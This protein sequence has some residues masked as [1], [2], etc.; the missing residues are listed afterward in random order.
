LRSDMAMMN[1]SECDRA[2]VNVYTTA[3][4]VEQCSRTELLAF[5]NSFIGTR[6]THIEEM[7]T[8]AAYC[9]LTD[10]LF[11]GRLPLK[12]VKFNSSKE[13]DWIS[14][15]H[16]LQMV[17]DRI[18]VR[19]NVPVERLIRAK[20]Q[21][22]LEFLQWFKKF[23]DANYSRHLPDAFSLKTGRVFSLFFLFAFLYHLSIIHL[24][25][26]LHENAS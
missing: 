14:N 19:K 16:I 8:G 11:P 24:V 2:V 9:Q 23:F 4:T 13:S 3:S 6:F 15:W 18:G 25:S 5:V 10:V 26:H 7:A 1:G 21:D 22:N 20:F 12:K 17:W